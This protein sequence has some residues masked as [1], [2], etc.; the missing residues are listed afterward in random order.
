MLPELAADTPAAYAGVGLHDL[1][2]AMFAQMKATDILR[3]Q[4]AAFSTLPVPVMTPA[5]AYSKLVHNEIEEV[6]IDQLAG[7]VL[8]TAWCRT[9]RASRC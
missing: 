3:L 2:D 5:E 4:A 6:A 1:A 7:R 8:A 9:R